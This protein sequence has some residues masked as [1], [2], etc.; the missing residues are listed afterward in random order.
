MTT[1]GPGFE[2]SLRR[3]ERAVAALEGGELGLDE[4]LARYEEGVR[5]LG[6]CKALLDAAERRV[7]L[8]AGVEDDGTPRAAPFQAPP[9]LGDE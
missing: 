8:L 2:E 3:L 5:L 6:R 7:A 4:A 9:T 1:D